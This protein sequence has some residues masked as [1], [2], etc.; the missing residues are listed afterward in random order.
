[1]AEKLMES[2]NQVKVSYMGTTHRPHLTS[3]HLTSPHLQRH[4]WITSS[5]MVQVVHCSLTN[6]QTFKHG[7]FYQLMPTFIARRDSSLGGGWDGLVTPLSRKSG[8]GESLLMVGRGEGKDMSF[9]SSSRLVYCCFS[10]VDF[11][12]RFWLGVG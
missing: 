5:N 1:M 11:L 2:V 10:F 8:F 3:P 12:S 9:V 6:H 7:R 4:V